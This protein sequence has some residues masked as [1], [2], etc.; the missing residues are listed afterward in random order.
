MGTLGPPGVPTLVAG[1]RGARSLLP[2]A[3]LLPR[4]PR[5]RRAGPPRPP[6]RRRRRGSC[7]CRRG[8]PGRTLRLSHNRHDQTRSRG[9]NITLG[10]RPNGLRTP[11]SDGGRH[12]ARR[13]RLVRQPQAIAA[14]SPASCCVALSRRGRISSP[15]TA[16][17]RVPRAF[18]SGRFGGLPTRPP[19]ARSSLAGGTSSRVLGKPPRRYCNGKRDQGS[20]A[21]RSTGPPC[22][23]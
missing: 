11:R 5:R 22:S 17:G 14:V 2:L 10:R 16:A 4:R 15:Q 18:G 6:R 9:N 12:V 20:A 23:A 1:A 8:H 7:R 3:R 13:R 19:S 21:P